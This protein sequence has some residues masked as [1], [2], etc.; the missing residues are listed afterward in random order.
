MKQSSPKIDKRSFQ[1]LLKQMRSMAPFY[2][3]EWNAQQERE[4]G[5]ALLK[6]YLTMY[7]QI[8]S[9][10]ND[11]P[12]KN[13]VA[14]YDMLG[15]KMLPAQSATVPVTFTLTDGAAENVF[16]PEGTEL[17]GTGKNKAGE[18][19]EVLFQTRKNLSA[20]PAAIREI[21]S[22]DAPGDTIYRHSEFFNSQ[23]EFTLFQGNNV[24]EHSLYIA[25]DDLLNQSM[26]A[27]ITV[28]FRI[29]AG[30]TGPVA[31]DFVW[32]YWNGSNWVILAPLD[33]QG[34]AGQST[35]GVEQG[36]LDTTDRFQKSGRMLLK[37]QHNGEILPV[38]VFEIEKRWIRCRLKNVLSAASPVN[39]PTLNTIRLSV[40]PSAPFAPDLLFHHDIPLDLSEVIL[41]LQAQEPV[42]IEF[43]KFFNSQN[44]VVLRTKEDALS[45]GN[46]LEFNNNSDPP[47]RQQI[48][49]IEEL[50][51]SQEGKK[52]YKITLED[53]LEYSYDERSSVRLVI[54]FVRFVNIDANTIDQSKV[55]LRFSSG[56]LVKGDFL[57][58]DNRIDPIERRRIK[59]ME[60]PIGGD[61]TVTLENPL[62]SSSY[63]KDSSVRLVTSLRPQDASVLIKPLEGE[64]IE[65]FNIEEGGKAFLVLSGEKEPVFIEAKNIAENKLTLERVVVQTL[66]SFYIEGDALRILPLIKPFGEVP[67]LSDTFF[68]ASDEA[69]SKKE[70]KVTIGIV[71][72]RRSFEPFP[73]SSPPEPEPEPVLSWEYWNGKSWRGIRVVDT[74]DNLREDGSIVFTCPKDIEKVEVNGEEKFWIRARI[75]EGDYGM[76]ADIPVAVSG[77]QVDIIEGCVLAPVIKELTITYTDVERNPEECVT[78]NNF[79]YVKRTEECNDPEKVF[80]PF[81]IFPE[82]FPALFLGFHKPL[83]SGP[84]RILFDLEEQFLSDDVRLKMEWYYWNGRDWSLINMVD[85]TESLTKIGIMEWI[86]SVDFQ[87]R[88]LF[89]RKLYWLKAL[90]A[91]GGH[92]EPPQIKEIYPNTVNALQSTVAREE[93]LGASN[94]TANQ[95]F[96]FLNPLIIAQDVWVKEPKM[97][98][99]DEQAVIAKE[100]GENAILLVRDDVGEIKETW[101]RW[102]EV[103][104]F[105]NS[106]SGSRHYTMNRRLGIA[107][108]GDGDKGMVPPPGVDNIKADYRF[109]GGVIG[110]VPAGAITSLKNAIA[111]VKEVSNPL[112]ADGGSETETLDEVL[113]RAPKRLKNRDRAVAPEDF[114]ALAKNAARKIARSKCLPNIDETGEFA[115]GWVTVLIV[116]DSKENKPL[117]TRQLIKQV[118]DTLKETSANVVATPDHIHVQGVNYVEVV[119]NTTIIPSDIN[120]AATVE[121]A[122]RKALKQY[123]NPLTGGPE[124]NGWEFGR[125]VC[126]SEI[127]ALLESIPDV[128][129]IESLVLY[130]NG[131]A[132]P[133]DVFIDPFSLPF[134]GEHVVNLKLPVTGTASQEQLQS[135]CIE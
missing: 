84:L 106:E 14:F 71:A 66:R 87:E 23:S 52:D 38:K 5:V 114:E 116:P 43:V 65:G 20:S 112:E 77:T 119:V 85:G 76:E 104:D 2:T 62:T 93:I 48:M 83:I 133:R 56:Q 40:N 70:A 97:P 102:H 26:P 4:P 95:E 134:S 33:N 58:F 78:L 8:I 135:E 107:R 61:P 109:G 128:D 123:I 64:S 90:V 55:V 24:Q 47:E 9:R 10:L 111:F 92:P 35:G 68:I 46:L 37:K 28:H 29:A 129:F 45:K 11:V 105:D 118:T 91:E 88:E 16:V 27:H 7:E 39:L 50:S 17:A 1:A 51:E 49:E 131:K 30:T 120:A 21:F 89:D 42:D 80:D 41:I 108:F 12:D 130:A 60:F 36:D 31:L 86:G 99:E 69:F 32:E 3:P 75:I 34:N 54:E 82:K 124:K 110:N 15:I 59:E 103:E 100:E 53:S 13:L 63:N 127:Y 67:V 98:S 18:D 74:T 22:A 96:Q 117:P 57:E 126:L 73:C 79:D 132:Q 6:I 44:I 122:V 115:P 121:D 81:A 125:M 19:E 94:G 25:H 101:V 113:I 72:G